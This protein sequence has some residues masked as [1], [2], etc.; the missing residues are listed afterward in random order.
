MTSSPWPTTP[1]PAR[2]DGSAVTTVLANAPSSCDEGIA[3]I[4]YSAATGTQL[5]LKH[6]RNGALYGGLAVSRAT[7]TVFIP[8]DIAA[9]PNSGYDY[10]TVAYRG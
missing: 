8:G 10:Y 2:S 9:G 7:N 6:V 5:W 3:T 4:A 1:Q